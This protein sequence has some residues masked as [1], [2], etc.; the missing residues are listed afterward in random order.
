MG[1]IMADVR[2]GRTDVG[3]L[4]CCY[5]FDST[6]PYSNRSE[7]VLHSDRLDTMPM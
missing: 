4:V 1:Q 2:R 7:E 5:T 3:T 6:P